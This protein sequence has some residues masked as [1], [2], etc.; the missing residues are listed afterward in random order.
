[1]QAETQVHE[2]VNMATTC[3]NAR[4]R[5]WNL[6]CLLPCVLTMRIVL[7]SCFKSVLHAFSL[8]LGDLIS[9]CSLYLSGVFLGYRCQQ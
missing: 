6:A 5:K 9:F 8:R 7:L 1:M 4:A 3:A 2:D